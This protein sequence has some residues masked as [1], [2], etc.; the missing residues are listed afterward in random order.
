[1][2]LALL[3]VLS[4]CSF[5]P[6]YEQPELPVERTFNTRTE[7]MDQPDLVWRTFFRDPAMRQLIEIALENNRDLRTAALNVEAYQAQYRIS[8]SDL[9]PKF[10]V[11]GVESRRRIPMGTNGGNSGSGNT[12][13]GGT[14][15][16]SSNYTG[17]GSNGSSATIT[18]WY[19]TTMD[20][21]WQIDLFGRLNSL[22]EQALEQYFAT[23][24]AHRGVQVSLIANVANAWLSWQADQAQLELSQNTLKAYEETLRLTQSTFDL[25]TASALDVR[26][27]Q[28]TVDSTRATL[29]SYARAVMLDRNELTLLLGQKIPD[30]IKPDWKPDGHQLAD[31]P[32][33]MSSDLLLQR[34]DII[35]AEYQLRAANA[36]IGAARSAFFPTI[37][38]S[39]SAGT[40]GGSISDLFEGGS[41][42][43]SFV[44]SISLPI[45]RAGELMGNL[46]YAKVSKNMQ[47]SNYEQAIQTAFR[48]VN[49]GLA[50]R[51]TYHRQVQAQNDLVDTSQDYYRLA[52]LR[53]RTGVDNYLTLLDAQRQ[54]FSARQQLIT[55]QLDQ[56]ISEV[57]LFKALGGGWQETTADKSEVVML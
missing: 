27:A 28:T 32:V 22:R 16:T 13:S 55:D 49:D 53:Y 35:E 36:N 50:A 2:A 10:N 40:A 18:S 24:A 30:N 21:S 37:T 11:S 3:L 23:E 43:W 12:T 44:P 41:G 4:G 54:L 57:N 8:R 6:G 19:A 9:F 51:T 15:G 48:E 56:H 39:A 45:F 46:D 14:S 17:P 5:I 34:P 7:E 42:Y 38:L 1:M 52:E 20:V 31:F 33:G 26:Q 47:V 29:E 25:G